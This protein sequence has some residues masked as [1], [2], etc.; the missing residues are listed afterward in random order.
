VV[1]VKRR[2]IC[3]RGHPHRTEAARQRCERKAARP[4]FVQAAVPS[5]QIQDTG[6]N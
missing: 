5:E 3:D 4:L 1:C 2:Y 6:E